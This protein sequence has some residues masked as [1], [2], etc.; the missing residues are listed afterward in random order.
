MRSVRFLT[1][2]GRSFLRCFHLARRR[3]VCGSYFRSGSGQ[4][5]FT[6]QRSSTAPRHLPIFLFVSLTRCLV[7]SARGEPAR[8][9]GPVVV[10]LRL[11]CCRFFFG[12]GQKRMASS[13][14]RGQEHSIIGDARNVDASFRATRPLEPLLVESLI[15][16]PSG[17][18]LSK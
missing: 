15:G 16:I 2:C 8:L 3:G 4:L 9:V 11:L 17:R 10:I 5:D 1:R 7:A 6:I 13:A 14:H 18:A 12:E